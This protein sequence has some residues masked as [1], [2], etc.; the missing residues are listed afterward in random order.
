[1]AP[2]LLA[3]SESML[4]Y[5]AIFAWIGAILGCAF[6]PF[7]GVLLTS[8]NKIKMSYKQFIQKT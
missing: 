5:A 8:L 7:H 3:V 1:M 2:T 4:I 6:S